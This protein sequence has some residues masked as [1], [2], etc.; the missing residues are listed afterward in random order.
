MC[1]YAHKSFFL[2]EGLKVAFSTIFGRVF[3]VTSFIHLYGSMLTFLQHIMKV[4]KRAL[5]FVLLSLPQNRQFFLLSVLG[6]IICSISLLFMLKRLSCAYLPMRIHT[7]KVQC[8]AFSLALLGGGL[9]V[10]IQ[11]IRHI[12]Q[13]FPIFPIEYH[14]LGEYGVIYAPRISLVCFSLAIGNLIVN[15]CTLYAGTL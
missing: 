15:L 9:F 5:V 13:L 8:S 10:Y 11:H 2:F 6:L 14:T 1:L 12:I 3:K 7:A 4:C